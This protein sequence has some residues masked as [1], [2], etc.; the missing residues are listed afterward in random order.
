MKQLHLTINPDFYNHLD[1]RL[2][3]DLKIAEFFN[4][5]SAIV[6]NDYCT[7]YYSQEK[8]RVLLKFFEELGSDYQRKFLLFCNDNLSEISSSTEEF[9]LYKYLGYGA[10]VKIDD[11]ALDIVSMQNLD[12]SALIDFSD[13]DKKGTIQ[14]VI[15]DA[16]ELK[17]PKKWVVLP[18][19][20]AFLEWSKTINPRS[21]DHN[22][23]AKHRSD[24]Q[25]SFGSSI[26]STKEE[27]E[28]ILQLAFHKVSH[29]EQNFIFYHQ[30]GTEVPILF[31]KSSDES[32]GFHGYHISEQEARGKG[33]NTADLK[34]L[35]EYVARQM[36]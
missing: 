11:G 13:D 36:Q 30:E 23:D 18:S 3:G 2:L 20:S 15:D 21:F 8:D 22:M 5:I 27:A 32:Q 33:V 19:Y 12:P 34:R 4:R 1:D 14:Y 6:L 16:G 31:F 35:S 28:E 26:H 29:H 24:G 25:D 10:L 17:I 9:D 7:F